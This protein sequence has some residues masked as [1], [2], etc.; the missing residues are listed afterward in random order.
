MP[1]VAKIYCYGGDPYSSGAGF[2]RDIF[3][4]LDLTQKRT[5]TE[6]Q[7]AWERVEFDLGKSNSDFG[8]VALPS[9][10]LIFMDGG[11]GDY[12]NYGYT[13]LPYR[14]ETFNIEDESAG[15]SPITPERPSSAPYRHTATLGP[16]NSTIYIWGGQR[17]TVTGRITGEDEYP[18]EM[19]IFDSTNSVS[20]WSTGATAPISAQ[21]HAAVLVG[22]SI[23]YIGGYAEGYIP[24][25]S[26]LIF[27]TDSG[28]W[29]TRSISGSDIPSTRTG[30]TLTLKPSTGEIILFGNII[31]SSYGDNLSWSKRAIQAED[32]STSPPGE[33]TLGGH[34][35]DRSNLIIGQ[36]STWV[37]DIDRWTWVSS[38]EAI[39]PDPLSTSSDT[40]SQPSG[41][42]NGSDGSTVSTG[43]VAGAVVGGVIGSAIIVAI[44]FY[45]I[46]RKRHQ[47]QEKEQIQ[48]EKGIKEEYNN[49]T[50]C[51]DGVSSSS[52]GDPLPPP[53]DNGNR[54]NNNNVGQ[55]FTPDVVHDSREEYESRKI[56]ILSADNTD[57]PKL[58]QDL[59][60]TSASRTPEKPDGSSVQHHLSTSVKPDGA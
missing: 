36:N 52:D 15:W 23:Y 3:I 8:M 46:R 30:H 40:P 7:S 48:E 29:T 38:V 39:Q 19:L 59:L 32:D 22:S 47:S 43:T 17:T 14:S 4:S 11:V 25:D 55:S 26:T 31:G 6:M 54:E 41:N 49:R 57:N 10:N 60:S 20:P 24:M 9:Q 42:G 58:S 33:Y 13:S 35:V 1:T 28:Q 44:L 45:I 27:N 18:R 51:Q 50:V 56:E 16:D 21:H 12:E 34:S 37:M 53:P 2:L 5:I